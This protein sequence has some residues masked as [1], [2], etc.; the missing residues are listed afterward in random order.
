MGSYNPSEV[1]TNSASGIVGTQQL[2]DLPSLELYLY[3]GRT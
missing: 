2:D 3:V 1:E